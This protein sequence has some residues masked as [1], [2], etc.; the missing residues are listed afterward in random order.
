MPARVIA[1]AMDSA[2]GD[3]VERWMDAGLLPGL[4]RLRREGAWGRIAGG[5]SYRA[6]APWTTLLTGCEPER[7]GYWTELAFDPG[8]YRV[9]ARGAY[10]FVAHPQFHA[11]GDARRVAV[12]DVPQ[13]RPSPDVAG[14]QLIGWGAHEPR[15]PSCS[16]PPELFGELVDRHG[17]HPALRKDHATFWNPVAVARLRRQLRIGTRRRAAI[18]ADLLAREP[19]DLFLTAFSETHS[20]GHHLWHLSGDTGHPLYRRRRNDPL[21]EAYRAVDR[22]TE[23]LLEAAG[24]EAA[25]VVFSPYGMEA[26]TELP[27]MVFLPE[28]CYRLSFPGRRALLPGGDGPP[29]P[30]VRHPRALT[31]ER[32]LWRTRHPGAEGLRPPRECGELS[33]Q[34][35]AWYSGLWPRMRAF[36]LPGGVEGYVRVNLAGRE[37]DGIV[38]PDRYEAV[39]AELAE[40]L[41]ELRDPRTGSP[42]VSEV[43][44]TR[45][46]PD[47]PAPGLPDADLVVC[48]RSGAWDVVDS[49]AVGR[50]GPVPFAR[51]GTHVDRGFIALRAPGAAPGSHLPA[52]RITDV[53]AT[54]LDLVGAPPRQPI[55]GRP[56]LAAA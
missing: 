39:C 48:W 24:P 30:V 36:A 41:N 53:T 37:R 5:R 34:P 20:A 44:R 43:L 14:P 13:T 38:P 19:W 26:A 11:L 40:R 17:P 29:A 47:D 21:L 18:C 55:D 45:S 22:A 7:T 23:G 16:T 12:V 35:A 31:W 6:E 33:Y 9:E 52:G 32:W 56:L 25:A 1:I 4:A 49:P 15:H 8:S 28:L 46:G 50:L 54:I 42:V 51:T 27:S 10:D 3:F 2:D